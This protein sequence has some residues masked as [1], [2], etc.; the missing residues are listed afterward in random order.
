M[1]L[2]DVK[3]KYLFKSKKKGKMT[4]R[5]L[6]N[7]IH[8]YA[9]Y[10]DVKNNKKELRFVPLT[11]IWKLDNKRWKE[12]KKNF[13]IIEKFDKDE[14]TSNIWQAKFGIPSG[15][16]NLYYSTDVDGKPLTLNSPNIV[17]K[18]KQIE[19][20]KSER[21]KKFAKRRFEKGL[22]IDRKKQK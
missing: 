5:M 17:F 22:Y 15:V 1:F 12:Y 11:H 20:E 18:G 16:G 14:L 19:K 8:T 9:A 13:V 10:Y 3:N 6:D 7:K 21:I 2:V 4:K